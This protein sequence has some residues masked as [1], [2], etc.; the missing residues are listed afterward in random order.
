MT[1]PVPLARDSAEAGAHVQDRKCNTIGGLEAALVDAT[2]MRA[3]PIPQRPNCIPFVQQC[4][5]R[6]QP[7]PARPRGSAGSGSLPCYSASSPLVCWVV[8][9]DLVRDIDA[10]PAGSA[11]KQ[12]K[13]AAPTAYI[14][15][16]PASKSSVPAA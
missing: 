4:S 10:R 14:G 15:M 1:V 5:A 16:W 7:K 8:G 2:G 6:G 9:L 3:Y 12:E 13:K 11:G